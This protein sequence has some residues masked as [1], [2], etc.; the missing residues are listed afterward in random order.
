MA[1]ETLTTNAIVF[2]TGFA[3]WNPII[4]LLIIS[5]I[6]TIFSTLVY[7]Y[8]TDQKTVKQVKE[9][10]KAMQSEMKTLKDNPSKMLEKQKEIMEKNMIIMKNSFKPLIF[11]FIPLLIVLFLLRKTYDPLGKILFGLTWLWIYIISSI[12]FNLILRKILK[13]Y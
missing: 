10:M 4:S 2:L 13:V 5:L 12:I 7:K 8:A 3:T 1:L 11:T 9:E 6:I